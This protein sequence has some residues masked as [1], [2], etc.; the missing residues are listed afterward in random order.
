MRFWDITRTQYKVGDFVSW[1][2]NKLL[3]L[4]P[5]YQ[6]R[7]VWSAGKKSYLIDTIIRGLPIPII[8]LRERQTDLSSYE[9]MREVVDGQQRI[10]T[11]ISFIDYKILPD[12]KEER[13]GFLISKAHNKELA[14]YNF[15]KLQDEY[16][17]KILDYQFSVH[18]L[19]NNVDDRE[20]LEIFSRLNSTGV[21]LNSQELRNAEFFGEFKTSVYKQAI[22][23]LSQWRGWKIFT[24]DNIS[25]MQ[26]VELTGELYILIIDG[27]KA[28]TQPSIDG[29]YKEYD[30]EFSVRYEVE[31]RFRST[32]DDIGELFGD[33]IQTTIFKKKTHFYILFALIYHIKYGIKSALFKIKPNPIP[34]DAVKKIFDKSTIISQRN[35]PS[36]VLEASDRRTTHLSSRND[37][38]NYF[39]DGI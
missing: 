23:Y 12:F 1:Q 18:V 31:K 36:K 15:N 6:R 2:K 13:D 34:S 16:K 26:E 32:M 7:S 29:Y 5:R 25:R 4:H 33:D 35:A 38:F 27:I 30:N 3:D 19:P 10:R 14:R 20:I 22:T 17:R 21:K 8:F 24:E 11:L 9:P 37:L 28:R 39:I